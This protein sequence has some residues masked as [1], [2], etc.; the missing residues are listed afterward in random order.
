M[1]AAAA[2]VWKGVEGEG[3]AVSCGRRLLGLLGGDLQAGLAAEVDNKAHHGCRDKSIR[4][5]KI[6]AI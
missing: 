5:G 1:K 6:C 4:W 3:W 2:A